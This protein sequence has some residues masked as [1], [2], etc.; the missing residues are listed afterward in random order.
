M[1]AIEKIHRKL[2]EKMG[3]INNK[4]ILD[5]G[6]GRGGLVRMLLDQQFAP[7]VIYAVDA[8]GAM[9]RLMEESFADY[10][11]RKKL[12]TKLCDDP[13]NLG[14]TKFD[15]VVCHNV[16]ECI[17]NKT[18]FIQSLFGLL[19]NGG[20][21]IISHHDFDSA[22]YNSFFRDLTRELIHK[23]AD[24]CQSWQHYCD[25]QMGRKIPGILQQAGLDNFSFETWR[26]VE[27]TFTEQDY[28]FLMANMIIESIGKN[29]A[30]HDLQSWKKDL[31]TKAN[32]NEFCFA[33]D[34]VI[35][36]VTNLS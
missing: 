8:D 17:E 31:E 32:N 36:D 20:I 9:L 14:D 16:L 22:I 1:Q 19:N 11:H 12:V 29:F 15:I 35:A 13:R 18:A 30:S 25:G 33:I 10:I 21:L 2:I 3:N 7:R 5:Y 23:F 26:I 4:S 28:G 27:T 6:C 34:L 24:T